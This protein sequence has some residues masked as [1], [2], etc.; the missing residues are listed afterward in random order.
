MYWRASAM[1]WMRSSCL[2]VAMGVLASQ[3]LILGCLAYCCPNEDCESHHFS[4]EMSEN[5]PGALGDGVLHRS[6]LYRRADD[7]RPANKRHVRKADSSPPRKYR[8]GP[9][10]FPIRPISFEATNWVVFK[11]T[12]LQPRNR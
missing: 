12:Y 4:A 7:Y 6:V 8:M 1:D 5:R 3:S 10:A 9:S 11:S 2:M